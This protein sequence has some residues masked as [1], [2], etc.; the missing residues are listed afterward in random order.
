[1]ITMR[2][3]GLALLLAAL[4][5]TL[6]AQ[7]VRALPGERAREPVTGRGFESGP[8]ANPSP[9]H[10]LFGE[11]VALQGTRAE[12]RSRTG[13]IIEVDCGPAIRTGHFSAPLFVGKLVLVEGL[14]SPDRIMHAARITRLPRLEPT[15]APDD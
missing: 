14:Y 5:G 15:L 12:V 3:A 6:A 8:Y 4:P 10:R 1:M 7:T 11:I 9:T 13:R 2:R